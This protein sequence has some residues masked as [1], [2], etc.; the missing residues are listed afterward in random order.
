[1]WNDLPH[2]VFD[3]G[4]L[5]GFE[6]AL[7]ASSV[8]DFLQFS[9]TQVLVGLQKQFIN[10]FVFPLLVLKIIIIILKNIQTD[11]QQIKNKTLILKNK[12]KNLFIIYFEFNLID[13]RYNMPAWK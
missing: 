7:V 2:T 11:C 8:P 3:T 12:K 6:G 1:M 10:N 9:V 5:D 13:T 4:T